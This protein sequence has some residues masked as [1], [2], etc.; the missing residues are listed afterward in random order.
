MK[1]SSAAS[2]HSSFDEALGHVGDQIEA[3]LNGVE[4]NLMMVFA[5]PHHKSDFSSLSKRIEDRF[6]QATVVGC[7]GGGVIGNGRELE[8]SPG[9]SVTAAHLPDV[10]IIPFHVGSVEVEALGAK[11]KRW[12]E[13]IGLSPDH[14]PC[15]LIMPEPFTCDARVLTSSL[16]RAYP[17]APKVGGVASG[18]QQ[19]GGNA[20]FAEGLTQVEGVVGVALWGD[21]RMDT[22][23]AQGCRPVGEN[24]I[25]TSCDQ[26]VIF[27]LDGHPCVDILDHVYSTLDNHEQLL[28]AHSPQVGI[29]IE[30]GRDTP[31]RGDFLVRNILG[32]DRNK[33]AIAVG[34]IPKHGQTVRF[35]IRDAG[36]SAEDLATLLCSHQRMLGDQETHGALIFSCLGRG[37]RFYGQP[38]HDS[39]LTQKH[40]GQIALGGFFCN[41]EIGPVHGQTFLR[42]YTSSMGLF[43][44]RPWS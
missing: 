15:F 42:G 37:S 5:T 39:Q 23:V 31:R 7:S 11:P 3:E 13:R 8:D 25:V 1:W 16:D 41:G 9:L 12:E 2:E 34:A 4:P 29:A 21:L 38:D 17:N 30:D 24:F 26:N 32:A 43:R 20:L 44:P 19:P 10:E 6:S 35:H 27:Q 14:Q 33:G 22:L 28:F 36:T 18:A 40:L